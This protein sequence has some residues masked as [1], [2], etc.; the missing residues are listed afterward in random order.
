MA[1]HE[2]FTYIPISGD[3][4]SLAGRVLGVRLGSNALIC[5]SKKINRYSRRK[6]YAFGSDGVKLYGDSG[7][8]ESVVLENNF[9]LSPTVISK[10]A[11]GSSDASKCV[12]AWGQWSAPEPNNANHCKRIQD[13]LGY[14][15]LAT[16]HILSLEYSTGARPSFIQT[17]KDF[18]VTM[19]FGGNRERIVTLDD[20]HYYHVKLGTMYLTV[21]IGSYTAASAN[22][23]ARWGAKW[24]IAQSS[25][26]LATAV[27]PATAGGSCPNE[28]SVSFN[29]FSANIPNLTDNFG[30]Y[31][32]AVGL[33]PK[34]SGRTSYGG[35]WLVDG[36]TMP[37]TLINPDMHA[38]GFTVATTGEMA[39]S[40]SGITPFTCK[41]N[42]THINTAPTVTLQETTVGGVKGCR[43]NVTGTFKCAVSEV[44]SGRSGDGY[45][46]FCLFVTSTKD[47]YGFVTVMQKGCA[48]RTLQYVDSVVKTAVP[49]VANASDQDVKDAKTWLKSQWPEVVDL[50]SSGIFLPGE[51]IASISTV[52][53]EVTGLPSVWTPNNQLLPNV[54]VE[55]SKYL[56]EL[57]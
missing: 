4:H 19:K 29:L 54:A 8:D 56:I 2:N 51:T 16:S 53:L 31:F 30:K 7:D 20:C 52:T 36:Y 28:L 17:N 46:A 37:V 9:G 25:M 6:P 15:H 12:K 1:D 33:A 18:S 35:L 57:R 49:G 11:D 22:N 48:E 39:L 26:T 24:L 13:Y 21:A 55:G 23:P 41:V 32:I 5:G 50:P 14:W 38:R 10:P 44:A 43:V 40:A 42:L 47:N 3:G 34:Y 45:L 27:K